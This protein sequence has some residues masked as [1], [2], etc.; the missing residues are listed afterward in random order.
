MKLNGMKLF[1]LILVKYN[2]FYNFPS[3]I[4]TDLCS[5]KLLKSKLKKKVYLYKFLLIYSININIYKF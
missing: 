1:L 5:I 2:L 3:R 4:I